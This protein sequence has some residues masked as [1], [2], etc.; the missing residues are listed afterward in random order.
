MRKQI[1]SLFAL[2]FTCI[3]CAQDPRER[4]YYYEILE[5]NSEPKP[6]VESGAEIRVAE[7]LDRGLTAAVTADSKGLHISWRLLKNENDNVFF[8]LYRT[9]NGKTKRLNAL[10]ITKTTDFIDKDPVNGIAKYFVR[11]I[12]KR[13]ELEASGSLEVDFSA[14]N[15]SNY[16]SISLKNKTDK[17]GKLAVGDLNGDGVYDYIVRTPAISVDPG[18]QRGDTLGRTYKIEAYLYDGTFLWSYDLGQGIEPGVWYSPFIVYDFDGDGKAEVA[19]KTSPATTKRDKNGHVGDGEEYLTILNGMTGEKIAQVDWPERNYRYGNLNRQN[20]NQIGV[21]YLDGKTPYVLACRGTY[22]LMV[23]DAW[24][25]K[26]GKL[27]R[28]W[29]WD[30]DEENPVVRSMGSHNMICGDVDNDGRDEILLGSCMLDDNGTLLWS[31]GLG[32]PDKIYLTDI[33]PQRPGMEVFLAQETWHDNGRGVSV[34]DAATGQQIWN[35]GHKTLHVGDGMVTDFDPKNPGLEVFASE[36]KK[37]GSSDK[38]LLTAQGGYLGKNDDVPGCRN[39]VWWDGDLLRETFKGSDDQWGASSSSQG[40]AQQIY[41][42]KGETLTE[43]IQGDIMMIADLFGDWREEVVTALDGEI[44]VYHTNIPAL[45]KRVCLMQDDIY[46]NTIAHRS[47][48]YPQSPVPSYYLGL[49]IEEKTKINTSTTA[50]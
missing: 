48:G 9:V 8:N 6:K 42:W 44:R 46:R 34:V 35:I 23:V 4:T 25:L 49:P 11:P 18:S 14:I 26:N 22:K 47:M 33:D 10:P 30:G 38:Y 16:H 37:G 24:H 2:C 28:A 21:A 19:L 1:F 12:F 15:K 5:P 31:T 41:K 43:N 17:A 7:N 13:K 29:R 50:Q 27:E 20:R 40:R 39:W 36:D 3:I 45:D 32:H